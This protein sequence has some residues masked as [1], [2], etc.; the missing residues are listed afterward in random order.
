MGTMSILAMLGMLPYFLLLYVISYIK[1][2]RKVAGVHKIPPLSKLQKWALGRMC[3]AAEEH[4]LVIEDGTTEVVCDAERKRIQGDKLLDIGEELE[5][6][7]ARSSPGD[8]TERGMKSTG[9]AIYI[10][11][12]TRKMKRVLD[13]P[14]EQ[15]V[16]KIENALVDA[17]E[18]AQAENLHWLSSLIM[19]VDPEKL[20]AWLEG[21]DIN[22]V[23]QRVSRFYAVVGEEILG[24]IDNLHV[25]QVRRSMIGLN[26][27]G[28]VLRPS[29][30]ITFKTE[31]E[32]VSGDAVDS[33]VDFAILVATATSEDGSCPHSKLTIEDACNLNPVWDH[34][35]D[36]EAYSGPIAAVKTRMY[37][38]GI[39]GNFCVVLDM[40]SP[41]Y[42]T[43]L[44][45]A[46]KLVDARRFTSDAKKIAQ[47]GRHGEIRRKSALVLNKMGLL[48]IIGEKVCW[49]SRTLDKSVPKV[50]AGPLSSDIAERV[51]WTT[52]GS[53][54]L[55]GSRDKRKLTQTS[56]GYHVEDTKEQGF[57]KPGKKILLPIGGDTVIDMSELN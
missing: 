34:S 11:H 28:A 15:C 52:T 43:E 47:P 50:H 48:E 4:T 5:K 37:N 32:S 12:V 36:G 8:E 40:D 35:K 33:L 14:K 54:L 30:W 10:Y 44:T 16:Q 24:D 17:A 55:D 7:Y 23:F 41:S 19:T 22:D 38:M 27:S 9:G 51:G 56:W 1:P 39:A 21:K 46:I 26:F 53:M 2:T 45:N 18:R 31:K 25:P 20:R 6:V 57:V 3:D 42:V 13:I 49:A 29:R